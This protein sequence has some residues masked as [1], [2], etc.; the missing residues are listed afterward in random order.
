M[1]GAAG[2]EIIDGT[3]IITAGVI[4]YKNGDEFI[5]FLPGKKVSELPENFLIWVSGRSGR[6]VITYEDEDRIDF[7]GLYHVREEKGLSATIIRANYAPYKYK[8]CTKI[9]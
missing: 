3:G 5:L 2:E 9:K 4:D 7:Y 6:R 8:A 1:T